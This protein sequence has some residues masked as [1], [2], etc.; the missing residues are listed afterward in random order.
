MKKILFSF[1]TLLTVLGL[2]AAPINEQQARQ[3]AASFFAQGGR[4]ASADLTLAW[5]GNDLYTLSGGRAAASSTAEFS[6]LYIYNHMLY[7]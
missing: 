2:S 3:I 7:H 5:A 1:V 6:H 4:A